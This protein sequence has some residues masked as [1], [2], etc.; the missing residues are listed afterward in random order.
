MEPGARFVSSVETRHRFDAQAPRI[1]GT[2]AALP[3]LRLDQMTTTAS[4]HVALTLEQQISLLSGADFWRTRA[5][6][7]ASIPTIL[8]AD[9][10]HGLRVQASDADHLG[11]NMS[12][13]S[14]CFP[15]AVTLA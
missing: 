12:V 8:L 6:N 9:G 5:L 1:P 10:P 4:T 3:V 15:P 7:E 14:T 11:F 13:P 2:R